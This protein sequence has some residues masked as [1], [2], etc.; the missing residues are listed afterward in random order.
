MGQTLAVS[1][2]ELARGER[3]LASGLFLIFGSFWEVVSIC[4]D[5]STGLL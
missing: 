4:V 2:Q 3:I 5:E 1:I